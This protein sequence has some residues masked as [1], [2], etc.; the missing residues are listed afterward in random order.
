MPRA[1]GRFQIRFDDGLRRVVGVVRT[2]VLPFRQ[3]RRG[4]RAVLAARD[5][6]T[7]AADGGLHGLEN[8][9]SFQAV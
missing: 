7:W 1:I 4:R 8:S 2:A 6:R 9:A 5:A 3:D